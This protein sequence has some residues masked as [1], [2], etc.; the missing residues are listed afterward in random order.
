MI[1]TTYSEIQ[2]YIKKKHGRVVKS[3][4][5]AHTKEICGL[6][7]KRSHRRKGE[8]LVP[9]PDDKLPWIKR[10]SDILI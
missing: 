4:W 3:C 10:H 6:E 8:R 2:N 5:I 1:K 9:C 7:P